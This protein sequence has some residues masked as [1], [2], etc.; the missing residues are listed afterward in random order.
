LKR[1][2]HDCSDHGSTTVVVN[3][4]QDFWQAPSDSGLSDAAGLGSGATVVAWRL[5]G[6]VWVRVIRPSLPESSWSKA[7]QATDGTKRFNRED[8]RVVANPRGDS[9]VVAWSSWRQDG[10]GWGIFA[11]SFSA[12]AFPLTE[13]MQINQAWRHF[14]WRPQIH[15]CGNSLWSLWVNGTDGTCPAGSGADCATG[16]F[17]RRLGDLSNS[18]SLTD[19]EVNLAGDGPLASALSCHSNEHSGS[20]DDA[21]V[22]WLIRDGNEVQDKIVPT[23]PVEVSHLDLDVL[24]R[25]RSGRSYHHLYHRHGTRSWQNSSFASLMSLFKQV[26]AHGLASYSF[27]MSTSSRSKNMLGATDHV[28]VGQA[29]MTAHQ[30]LLVLLTDN[31]HGVLYAQLL[32]FGAVPQPVAYQRRQIAA[33]TT[34]T[35]AAWAHKDPA[36]VICWAQ[37]GLVEADVPKFICARR[38]AQYLANVTGLELSSQLALFAVIGLFC[39]LCCVRRCAQNGRLN[40]RFPRRRGFTDEGRRGRRLA[41]QA[42]LRELREQLA[43][44]PAAMVPIQATT[45]TACRSESSQGGPSSSADASTAASLEVDSNAESTS[46]TSSIRWTSSRATGD[47]CSICQNEVAVW[48]ALRPCGH[49]ACRECVG[50]IVE[51]NQKCHLCRTPIEGVLPVYI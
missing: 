49:T 35:R 39:V 22:Y 5:G 7:V 48:V 19:Q 17:A 30:E 15:W 26:T 44:I 43:Q 1:F 42:R 25:L 6:D 29:V 23:Q 36:L 32:N 27:F 28:E 12:A 2:G 50:R 45:S 37:G 16:P 40:N 14:Q 3:T 51:M 24:R 10:D 8:V 46:S 20:S 41:S 34:M 11:R 47:V 18:L 21:R 33:G 31:G 4:T 9:F 13:E 38:S